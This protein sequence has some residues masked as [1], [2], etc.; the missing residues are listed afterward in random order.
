MTISFFCFKYKHLL[1]TRIWFSSK[2]GCFWNH[3]SIKIWQSHFIDTMQHLLQDANMQLVP[4]LSNNWEQ[5]VQTHPDISFDGQTCC[6]SVTTCVVYSNRV[7]VDTRTKKHPTDNIENGI[8]EYF[9][10]YWQPVCVHNIKAIFQVFPTLC[11]IVQPLFSA[12]R[13]SIEHVHIVW[14][15]KPIAKLLAAVILVEPTYA[16]FP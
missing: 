12:R 6:S 1:R 8:D 16:I 3:R 15:L 10:K 13:D 5:A 7:A 11:N 2:I 9:L 4:D 14:K